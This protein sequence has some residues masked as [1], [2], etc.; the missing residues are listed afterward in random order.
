[1]NTNT[2]EQRLEYLEQANE[3]LQMQNRVLAT[4]FKGLLR[5]LPADTTE[6]ALEMIREAFENDIAALQYEDSPLAELYH[7]ATYTFFHESDH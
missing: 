1:M 2:I 7:D 5:A 6:T 3:A 4:A